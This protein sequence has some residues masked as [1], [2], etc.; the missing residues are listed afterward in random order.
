MFGWTFQKFST[1]NG[2]AIFSHS[3]HHS[4]DG[5]MVVQEDNNWKWKF[6]ANGMVISMI[7]TSSNTSKG[8]LFKGNFQKICAFP[9]HFNQFGAFDHLDVKGRYISIKIY[10][11]YLIYVCT[12]VHAMK[13][14]MNLHIVVNYSISP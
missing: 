6:C 9:L 14:F 13:N 12:S 3:F 2:K 11:I 7:L 1:S 10:L 4:C 8:C 5:A